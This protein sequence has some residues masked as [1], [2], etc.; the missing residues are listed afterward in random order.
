MSVFVEYSLQGG[1]EGGKVTYREEKAISA[2]VMEVE[3][4]EEMGR[5]IGDGLELLGF[6][7][8]PA[9]V[10]SLGSL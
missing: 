3:N 5:E 8:K 7:E 9:L 6:E 1:R 4:V 2:R 10:Q